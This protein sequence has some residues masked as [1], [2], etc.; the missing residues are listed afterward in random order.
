MVLEEAVFIPTYLVLRALHVS[1]MAAVTFALPMGDVLVAT[2]AWVRLARRGFFR[3]TH[4]PSI[5][6]ARQIARYGFRA[7]LGSVMTTVNARLDFALVAALMGPVPLGVYA[8]ASRYAELLRLPYL[9]LNYVLYPEYARADDVE[10]ATRAKRALARSAWV[11][12]A[13]ICPM[14][15]A[16]PIAIPLVFG[17]Q[18][19]GAIVPACVILVGLAGGGVNGVVTAYFS[20]VGRP[21]L[22]S[23]STGAGLAVGAVLYLSLIPPFGIIGAASASTAAYLVVTIALYVAFRRVTAKPSSPAASRSVQSPPVVEVAT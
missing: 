21:G 17:H 3:G 1:E 10:A 19:H 16:A 11:P 2:S 14:A 7:S 6:H 4:G 22:N 8:V 5:W 13:L 18:F 9:A 12:A 20:G 23:L 15:I